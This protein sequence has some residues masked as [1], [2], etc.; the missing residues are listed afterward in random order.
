MSILYTVGLPQFRGPKYILR[1]FSACNRMLLYRRSKALHID[2]AYKSAIWHESC[3]LVLLKNSHPAP[4]FA[5]L[6]K[7]ESQKWPNLSKTEI[8]FANISLGSKPQKNGFENRIFFW[9]KPN[10]LWF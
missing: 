8:S 10:L 7:M 9:F 3:K 6:L 2:F 5:K 1:R 4:T